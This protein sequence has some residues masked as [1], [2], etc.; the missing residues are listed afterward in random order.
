MRFSAASA[1]PEN[2]LSTSTRAYFRTWS[3]SQRALP[4]AFRSAACLARGAAAGVFKPGN[5]GS[6][7]GGN[8]LAC[9][10]AL[11][12]LEAIEQERLLENAERIGALIRAEL[13]QAL[14]DCK[15]LVEIRGCGLMVGSELDRPCG[16]LVTL[17][18]EAGLLINVTADN[19]VRL[20]PALVMNDAEARTLVAM[21]APLMREF[22]ARPQPRPAARA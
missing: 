6:T 3:R 15:G 4:G 16:E 10:A 5:H 2:G 7:F 21:L 8:P 22:L 1:A 19:V 17:A 20:L 12:T 14:Q 13:A 18:L 11:A 9:A